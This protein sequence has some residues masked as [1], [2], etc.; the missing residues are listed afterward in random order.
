MELIQKTTRRKTQKEFK[1]DSLMPEELNIYNQAELIKG[2]SEHSLLNFGKK[3][4]ELG[5]AFNLEGDLDGFIFCQVSTRDLNLTSEN[6]KHIQSLFTESMNI[7]L[8][9][10]LTDLED[11]TN[12]MS[13]ITHPRLI[14]K[15]HLSEL[16]KMD[17]KREITFQVDYDLITTF[18][19]LPCKIF[20][21]AHKRNDNR[22]V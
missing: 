22:E 15:Q 8:G 10:F 14:T 17:L 20:F 1:F 18:Y 16:E 2:K 19:N 9:R 13:L 3:G 4:S 21:C 6:S 5:I 11:E 7:L 12:L